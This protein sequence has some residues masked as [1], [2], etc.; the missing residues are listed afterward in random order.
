MN[1]MN[2]TFILTGGAGRV[3]NAIPALEKYEKLNPNDD[4]K[5]LVHGWEQ[6]F[7]SHPT[8]Q[9]RVFGSHQ[10][11]NFDQHIK[12]NNI[13]SPEPYQVYRFYNQQCNLIEAFDECI[14]KTTDHSDLNYNVL[15]LSNYE[16]I[17]IKDLVKNFKEKTKKQKV[18]VFQ[19]FGSSVEIINNEVID[20]SSRSLKLQDYFNIVKSISNNA[21]VLYASQ[22]ELR[23]ANDKLSISFDEY[24][25]YLRTLI[26]LI[27]QC[28]YFVGI[29]SVGQHIARAF[30]K[31]GLIMMGATNEIN[32]SYPN[33]FYIFRKKDR[34]PFYSPWRLSE[35]DCEFS[36]RMNNGIMEF[37]HQELDEIKETIN[38]NLTESVALELLSDQ[39]VNG[40]YN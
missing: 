21:T 25:P 38:L 28:D 23:H 30:N 15:H 24:Q 1:K 3:I 39:V 36:D 27:S 8:L 6:V 33:H 29:C 35:V 12:N 26:G 31:P 10:K 37:T 5:I 34:K 19:P 4:F 16:Q 9:Q 17:K 32:F 40:Q 2:T 22:P 18:V 7:W 13:V 14:N 20:R 11:G